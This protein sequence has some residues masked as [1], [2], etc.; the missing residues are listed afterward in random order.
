MTL[1]E[2]HEHV[3]AFLATHIQP[4]VAT[5]ILYRG[6]K[7]ELDRIEAQGGFTPKKNGTEPFA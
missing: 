3:E 5:E 1:K 6:D 7:R 2:F 4:K